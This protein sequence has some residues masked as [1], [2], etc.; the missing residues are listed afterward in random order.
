MPIIE[1]KVEKTPAKP[2]APK[3]QPAVQT[4]APK[5]SAPKVDKVF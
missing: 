3:P 1:R 2:A 4:P 5:T